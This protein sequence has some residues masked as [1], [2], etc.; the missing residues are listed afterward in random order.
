[1]QEA[2]GR[3]MNITYLATALVEIR[4]TQEPKSAVR[5]MDYVVKGEMLTNREVS[6]FVYKM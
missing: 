1:M 5:W 3:E 6:K 2:Y 4:A